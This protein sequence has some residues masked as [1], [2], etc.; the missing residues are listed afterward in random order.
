M[1]WKSGGYL[2][3]EIVDAFKQEIKP[4]IVLL[5][6]IYT[7]YAERN[8]WARILDAF[9]DRDCDTIYG[10]YGLPELD[11]V[12]A[13]RELEREKK[14]RLDGVIDN[15]EWEE[16]VTSYSNILSEGEIKNYLN[17]APVV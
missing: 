1:S 16:V 2:F 11:R 8:F 10:G 5:N 15:Y 17:I 3:D 14:Y 6:D 12:I 9:E 4:R 13:L 7:I